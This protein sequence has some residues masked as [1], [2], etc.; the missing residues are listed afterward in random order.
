MI[1][2]TVKEEEHHFHLTIVPFPP[3]F[4]LDKSAMLVKDMY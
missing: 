2:A 1:M 4:L 3:E